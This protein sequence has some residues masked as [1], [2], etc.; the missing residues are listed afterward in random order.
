MWIGVW[1]FVIGFIIFCR[2]VGVGGGGWGGGG[3]W[4]SLEFLRDKFY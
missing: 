4:L 2:V 3:W 1:I